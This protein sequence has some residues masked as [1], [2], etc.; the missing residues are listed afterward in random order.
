MVTAS[1][2]LP[3]LAVTT[4]MT[5]FA[6]NIGWSGPP[7]L[8]VCLAVLV[9]Q[10]SVGWSNDAFDASSD[11]RAGRQ[12]KPTVSGMVSSQTLWGSAWAAVLVSAV[13][14]WLAAGLV[15]GSIH[16]FALTMAWLYNVFLSRTVWSWLPYALAFGAMPLF[17]YIGLDGKPG[18]WWTV[19]VFAF[20][21]VSAHLANALPDLETDQ[22]A[23]VDGLVIRLGAR[24]STWLCWLLLGIATGILVVVTVAQSAAAWTTA[25]LVI[26]FFA[27]LLF[28]STSRRQSAMFLALLGVA[29]LDVA[30]IT[31]SP[32]L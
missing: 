21:A 32:V 24:L 29:L 19:C 22:S 14:S 6:W 12:E 26:G 10:L 20:V 4:V 25:V 1:H 11:A 30:A 8:I 23:G 13:L 18:P 3:T 17:L 16:V 28:G 15:G 5:V 31:L 9:G 2:S 27:A 7:L